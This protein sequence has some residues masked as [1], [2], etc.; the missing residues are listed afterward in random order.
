MVLVILRF[1][2]ND[3]SNETPYYLLFS[4]RRIRKYMISQVAPN[5]SFKIK[6]FFF[7][8]IAVFM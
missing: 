1:T 4:V 7:S 2:I 3:N 6:H 8:V 5:F